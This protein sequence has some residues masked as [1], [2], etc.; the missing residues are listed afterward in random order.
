M[1]EVPKKSDHHPTTTYYLWGVDQQAT[2]HT[3]LNIIYECLLN[4]KMKEK[5]VINSH[6]VF[7]LL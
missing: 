3:M 6:A 7:V 4:L 2:I 1:Q 5:A